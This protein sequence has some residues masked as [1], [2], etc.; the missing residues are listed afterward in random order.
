M[1]PRAADPKPPK[2]DKKG[3]L[4][5]HKEDKTEDRGAVAEANAVEE[6]R[7]LRAEALGG[8]EQDIQEE[9]A[10]ASHEELFESA[11]FQYFWKNYGC[12]PKY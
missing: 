9:M 8:I 4:A 6:R 1:H 3:K 7:K 10:A 12:K 11:P 2:P 5:L